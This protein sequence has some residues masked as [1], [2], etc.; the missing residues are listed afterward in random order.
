MSCDSTDD[1]RKYEDIDTGLSKIDWAIGN[2]MKMYVISSGN[3]TK[4][5]N[6]KEETVSADT[7]TICDI[8]VLENLDNHFVLLWHDLSQVIEKNDSAMYNAILRDYQNLFFYIVEI[9]AYG[10]LIE[11]QNMDELLNVCIDTRLQILDMGRQHNLS[12]ET[13]CTSIDIMGIPET[14]EDI[15]KDFE[16]KYGLWFGF[17]KRNI[18]LE[19]ISPSYPESG[20]RVVEERR[21]TKNAYHLIQCK[22]KPAKGDGFISEFIKYNYNSSILENYSK[23]T[24]K[25]TTDSMY[26]SNKI[27]YSLIVSH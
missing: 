1:I 8:S 27:E 9:D 16:Q 6:L 25:K 19:K 11:I 4:T 20:Y 13:I 7:V 18:D 12:E 17:Y 24:C 15:L 21:E 14:K 3:L 26:L 23:F 2:R 22:Y 10:C 5:K